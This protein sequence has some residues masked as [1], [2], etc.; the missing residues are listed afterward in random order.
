V[1]ETLDE[2]SWSVLSATVNGYIRMAVPV[3][4]RVVNRLFGLSYSPATIR[5]VMADLEEEGYLT[6]PHT[7]AGRIPTAKGFRYFVD[8]SS[9]SMQEA[10]PESASLSSFLDVILDE[11]S[12]LDLLEVLSSVMN[13]VARMTNYTAIVLE[14][15]T[16]NEE[17]LLSFELIPV[18]ERHLLAILVTDAGAVYKRT[19]LLPEGFRTKEIVFLGDALNASSRNVHL[20]KIREKLFDEMELLGEAYRETLQQLFFHNRM[21][22]MKLFRTSRFAEMPEFSDASVLHAVMEVFEEKIALLEIFEDLVRQGGV[23]VQIGSENPIP[24]LKP[25]T[26]VSVPLLNGSVWLGSVGLV[27]PVRMQ[28]DQVIPV[29]QYLSV[30][31]NHWI[32][33]TLPSQSPSTT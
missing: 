18:G 28:Y 17:R 13:L 24:G 33:K 6:H 15:G 21:P 25:C 27:G 12:P 4:S 5:N 11:S 1:S 9:F 3:G 32:Q 7:S 22:E 26:L 23:S 30:R 2:R 16:R 20:S 31:L 14:P 29:M 10:L 8:N 19:V